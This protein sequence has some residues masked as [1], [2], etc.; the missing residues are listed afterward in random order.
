LFGAGDESGQ[1]GSTILSDRLVPEVSTHLDRSLHRFR[2]L[3]CGARVSGHSASAHESMIVI[4]DLPLNV[5]SWYTCCV[6]L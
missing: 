6:L 3:C 4:R 5:A 1:G 2:E